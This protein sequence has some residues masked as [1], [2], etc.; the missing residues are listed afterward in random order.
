[1]LYRIAG[2]INNQMDLEDWLALLTVAAV[3]AWVVM[4][5]VSMYSHPCIKEEERETVVAYQ[6]VGTIMMPI[7]GHRCLE[8]K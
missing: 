3:I 8:N 7:Y 5:I 1:M 2:K 4:A 6:Q